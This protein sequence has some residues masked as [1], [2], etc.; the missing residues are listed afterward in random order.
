MWN[1]IDLS[2]GITMRS[3]T[4]LKRAAA[5]VFSVLLVFAA[6]SPQQSFAEG[7]AS[8]AAELDLSAKGLRIG[9]GAGTIQEQMVF[10]STEFQAS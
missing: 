5:F 3:K 9:V 4:I 10:D 1:I 6:V 7:T 8:E 2:E